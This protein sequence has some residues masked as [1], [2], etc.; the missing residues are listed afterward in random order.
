[1]R[2]DT[3]EFS[4]KGGRERN[5]DAVSLRIVEDKGIFVVADG[6]G[7]HKDGNLAS[8]KS[9]AFLCESW[10]LL[11]GQAFSREWM[12]AAIRK[13]NQGLLMMQEERR[14]NMRST[15]AM[16]LIDGER[17]AWANV[18]DTRIYYIRD[19]ELARV[20]EDHSMAFLKFKTGDILRSA[21]AKDPDQSR[22]LRSLG[23]KERNT[24]DI[25]E[26]PRALK[27][28][29]AFLLCT[30]G[31]WEYLKDEEVAIDY[32]KSSNARE[33]G[34]HLLLRVIERIHAGN[35]NLSFITVFLAEDGGTEGE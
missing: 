22:L 13:T 6:L 20:T 21:L 35:D 25:Y 7:G 28:G 30:D 24:P 29:D 18:G 16:L 5:E 26:N 4:S 10:S 3:F 32:L 34:E 8:Q 12:E 15:L 9:V 27:P 19:G 33:W 11:E 17:S 23:D 1:M 14:S 2:I 31:L